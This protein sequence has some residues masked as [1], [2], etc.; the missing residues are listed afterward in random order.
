LET[1]KLD[2]AQPLMD[3]AESFVS[4]SWN[5]VKTAYTTYRQMS[6]ESRLR[7][8]NQQ[9]LDWD[10]DR[11]VFRAA[12][13]NDPW[14]PMPNINRFGP[15]I[16]GIASNFSAVPEI[17]AIPVPLD[18]PRNMGVADVC[19]ELCDFVIKD[20]ALRS[21]YGS[22]EDRGNTARQMFTLGGCVFSRVRLE[23]KPIGQRPIETLQP[24]FSS[25]CLNCG[26]AYP[27]MNE[28]PQACPNCQSPQITIGQTMDM[29]PQ[30]NEAGEPMMETVTK[31]RCTVEIEDPVWFSPR[32]G[33][34]SMDNAVWICCARRIP[35]DDVFARTGVEANP[36]GEYP[37]GFNM[38]YQNELVYWYLGYST[39]QESLRDSCLFV[40]FW[41]EPGKKK[42]FPEGCYATYFNG[43]VQTAQPWSDIGPVDHPLT[44]GDFEALPGIFFPRAKAF[45]LCEIQASLT[46]LDSM[47]E[48]HL[49]TNAVEP[50][51][52]DENTVVSE[53][54]GRADKIVRWRSVGPGS[55]EPHRMTHGSMDPEI[56]QRVTYLEQ[57]G[58]AIAATVSVFRGE[59]PGSI[60]AASAIAQLRGQAEMQFA[61]AVKNWNNFWKE[62]VRKCMFF[63]QQYPMEELIDIVG[64]D[65]VNQINDFINADLKK[66]VEFIATSNG[67][68]R[69][70]DERRQE[71]MVLYDKGALDINDPAVRQKIFELFGDTGMMERFNT[72]A[73]R[74]RFNV[75]QCKEQKTVPEF[76]PNIDDPEIHNAIAIDAAK[77]MG[78]S[79]PQQWSPQ[80]QQALYTYIANIQS[81]LGQQ[82]MSAAGPG[83]P[84][85]QGAPSGPGGPPAMTPPTNPVT[86]PAQ[87]GAGA[88]F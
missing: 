79:D 30:L 43:K 41:C 24:S 28:P 7:Y 63:Y 20:C 4:E 10:K 85:P 29:K 68:P 36:D 37:D 46:K 2:A 39:P 9:W 70:R 25:Q 40:E 48:L 52:I 1:P 15:W 14:V 58:E 42:E 71:M 16:D 47:I 11:R 84:G 81:V 50:I 18:D 3:R 53:I 60:T 45:D 32:P 51:V 49:K 27:G 56:Y 66:A 12:S 67:L 22:R 17:E 82:A 64:D 33:A 88:G 23:H 74:A 62:T 73:T 55:R 35:V 21:D 19:N 57:K 34:T 54:T 69:T 6:W 86:P 65:K 13:P 78:F 44:K 8:A 26:A 31:P 59:Q 5:A 75:R 61:V 76:R 80:A 83:G 77:D 72:D 87:V 38:S